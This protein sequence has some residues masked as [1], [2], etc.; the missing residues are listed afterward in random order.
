MITTFN[1]RHLQSLHLRWFGRVDTRRL[2]RGRIDEQIRVVVLQDWHFSRGDAKAMM[3]MQIERQAAEGQTDTKKQRG[4]ARGGNPYMDTM[5]YR[6]REENAAGG[7]R[8][9]QDTFA[10]TVRREYSGL[11]LVSCCSIRAGGVG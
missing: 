3:G 2:S 4:G 8:R 9:Q 5:R 6:P 1:M 11:S 10:R 7:T